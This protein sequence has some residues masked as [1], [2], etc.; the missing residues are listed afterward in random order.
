MMLPLQMAWRYTPRL[1]R[2]RDDRFSMRRA[3]AEVRTSPPLF[4]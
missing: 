4:L 2:S 1:G 3:V